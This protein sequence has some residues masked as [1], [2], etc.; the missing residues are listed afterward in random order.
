MIRWIIDHT[1]GAI[2][3]EKPAYDPVIR[4]TL[5]QAFSGDDGRRALV[6]ILTDLGFFD[7]A[8]DSNGQPLSG[9]ALIRSTT[10]RDY[11]RRLLEQMGALH[12]GNA[13][14]MVN[15]IMNLPVWEEDKRSRG[16]HE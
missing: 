15:E 6:Y 12:E 13:Y 3:G 5:R 11:A 10:L 8:V 7:Q 2:T 14:Q 9:E 16:K 1:K 4:K